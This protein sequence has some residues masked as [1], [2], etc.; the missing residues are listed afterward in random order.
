MLRLL[1]RLKIS[2]QL[3][4]IILSFAV[5]IG[6]GFGA[7][8]FRW[9]I[10]SFHKVFF[11]G[12]ERVLS[13]LTSHWQYLVFLIPA[14]GGLLVGP[15]TYRL[16]K[17]VRGHG[18]PEVMQAVALRGGIIKPVVVVAKS[19]A[20]SICI[21]SGGS[22]GR[23][24]PIVQ[25]GSALGSSF[26]QFFKMS[27]ERVKVLVGCGAAAG[28]SA[29][30]NAPI[31]GVLFALEVILGD[32]TIQA[33]SPVIISSFVS[34]VVARAFLG[35]HP[36]FIVP[37]YAFKSVYEIPL[38][39]V[40]GLLAGGVSV[41]FIK[42]LYKSEDIFEKL[43]IKNYLKPALGGL[44]LGIIALFYPQILGV[45]YDSIK[46]AL[47]AEMFLGV[48]FLLVFLKIIATSLTLGSGGSGGI[49]A[50]SLFI[51]AMLGGFFGNAV[52][53]VFPGT[54]ASPGAYALVGM[55]ALVAGTTHATITAMLIIFEMTADYRIILALMLAS[56]LSTLLSN[57]LSRGESIYTLKLVRRGVN[58]RAGKDVSILSTTLVREVMSKSWEKIPHSMSWGRLLEF[59]ENSKYSFFPVVNS[60]D[61]LE[62]M[63]SLQDIRNLIT[64]RGLENLVIVRDV[65]P[66]YT[67]ILFED[68]TLA[69]AL[70]KFGL[71]DV[72][73]LP[74]VD[75]GNRKKLIGV[76]RRSDIISFYN[77]KL[78]ERSGRF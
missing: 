43:K 52:N 48:M 1:T 66:G 39:M 55:S 11:E 58:L 72:E 54:V 69:N 23:E 53:L 35:N 29:T 57:R 27:G 26:G 44:L 32:F 19:I 38:Y 16:A 41:L 76:L 47:H 71:Q 7:I 49:F 2:E 6:G 42:I 75:R 22:A 37:P 67:Q 15:I 31:A 51:G 40:L 5:G 65:V 30:F 33:F 10:I 21:G 24:G 13:S 68:E 50:P 61:E 70:P 77:R 4:L 73:A 46:A 36:A 18:V 62:G 63:L 12:G 9:L 20:S 45:G 8:V 25:I 59:V 17:E 78:I 56:V 64:K 28:I 3:F 60:K 34:S 14:V 74:V